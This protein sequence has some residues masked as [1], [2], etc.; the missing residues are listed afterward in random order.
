MPIIIDHPFFDDCAKAFAS[1]IGKEFDKQQGEELMRQV[2]TLYTPR[3]LGIKWDCWQIGIPRPASLAGQ[4]I[5]KYW[6]GGGAILQIDFFKRVETSQYYCD[7]STII[8]KF[9]EGVEKRIGKSSGLHFNL[10]ATYW[11][12]NIKFNKWIKHN[13]EEHSCSLVCDLDEFLARCDD[14]LREAFFPTPGPYD[15]GPKKRKNLQDRVLKE[16]A[17]NIREALM[18]DIWG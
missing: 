2:C 3:M 18:K 7:Y 8:G 4:D 5:V 14:Y 11:T 1:Q 16:F 6:Q 15:I 10:E 17:P 9:G 13:I 12:F